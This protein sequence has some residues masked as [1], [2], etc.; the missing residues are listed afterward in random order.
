MINSY[1]AEWGL[2]DLCEPFVS[3]ISTES[4]GKEDEAAASKES[5]ASRNMT[6]E[7]GGK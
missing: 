3:S 7:K 1:Q 6:V 4:D 5:H 2:T